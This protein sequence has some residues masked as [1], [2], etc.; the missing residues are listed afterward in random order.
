MIKYTITYTN[1][2]GKLLG[3][4]VTFD[5]GMAQVINRSLVNQN[6]YCKVHIEQEVIRDG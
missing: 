5:R 6:A 1:P 3:T 4:C 2:E